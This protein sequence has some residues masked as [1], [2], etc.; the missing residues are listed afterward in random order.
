L[1]DDPDAAANEL[2]KL[3]KLSEQ[4]AEGNINYVDVFVGELA[5]G[6]AEQEKLN[7][8]SYYI[9]DGTMQPW[10]LD[11]LAD[12][13]KSF[14]RL[15]NDEVKKAILKNWTTENIEK[16]IK[17]TSNSVILT[18]LASLIDL[19]KNIETT[20]ILPAIDPYG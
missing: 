2:Y 19:V 5:V 6:K 13:V 10:I 20:E 1:V 7:A 3:F 11:Y 17:S 8:I 9:K 12:N 14:S 18:P 4:D 16:Q 15:D